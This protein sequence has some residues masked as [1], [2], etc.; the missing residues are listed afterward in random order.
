MQDMIFAS[1]Q[2]GNFEF[3]KGNTL[4]TFAETF[5]LIYDL[6]QA[7]P[8]ATKVPHHHINAPPGLPAATS[9]LEAGFKSEHAEKFYLQLVS[10]CHRLIPF[11]QE[12]FTY[13]KMNKRV[14][15]LDLL[16]KIRLYDETLF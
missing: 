10:A 15:V 1:I 2:S 7:D 16:T 9:L 4:A 11:Y 12:F 13:Y 6:G 3:R 14:V 8:R 5:G